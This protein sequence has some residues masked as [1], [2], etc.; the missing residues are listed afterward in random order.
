MIE[1]REK[2]VMKNMSTILFVFLGLML[3]VQ[4]SVWAETATATDEQ[5]AQDAIVLGKVVPNA[6]LPNVIGSKPPDT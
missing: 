4:S 3:S 6:N 2:S 1:W 5:E